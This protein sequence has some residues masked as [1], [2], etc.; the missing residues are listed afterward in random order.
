MCYAGALQH[1]IQQQ[2]SLSDYGCRCTLH[3]E[4]LHQ[5]IH[6]SHRPQSPS[7][8]MHSRDAE[9]LVVSV[10][11]K[12]GYMKVGLGKAVALD[13]EVVQLLKQVE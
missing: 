1:A 3:T 6:L 13:K 11:L 12:T 4:A 7:L 5:G 2:P 8:S 9:L 10:Q